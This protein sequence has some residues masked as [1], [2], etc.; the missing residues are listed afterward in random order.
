MIVIEPFICSGH[1]S[2]MGLYDRD[3]MKDPSNGVDS[4]EVAGKRLEARRRLIILVGM[5]V[6]IAGLV[7]SFIL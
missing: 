7:L 1:I 6:V 4:D 5:A 3:Y 2:S